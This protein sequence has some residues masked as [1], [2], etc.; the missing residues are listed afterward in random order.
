MLFI[1]LVSLV[2]I[3]PALT[4][5]NYIS[6][7]ALSYVESILLS[8]LF[9]YIALS[10]LLHKGITLKEIPKALGI[11]RGRLNLTYIGYGILLFIAIFSLEFFAGSLSQSTGVAINTNSNIL[12]QGAPLAFLLFLA[13]ICPINEEILFRG[14]LFPR[15]GIVI[16]AV[17]FAIPHASYGSTFGIDIFAAFVFGIL[18]GYM[19]RKTG[20]LYPSI[21][22]HILV[23][24]FAVLAFMI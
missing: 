21:I 9:T 1:L 24:S 6:I 19:Y 7:E 15:I 13:V 4:A 18:S 5:W 10:W 14:L 8:F 20:S 2:F 17:L 11:D 16:S 12:I 3:F 22:A 23:N